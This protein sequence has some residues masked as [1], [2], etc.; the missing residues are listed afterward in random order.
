MA[1][2]RITHDAGM[3]AVSSLVAGVVS[4]KHLEAHKAKCEL[5]EVS[6]KV[7]T[8]KVTRRRDRVASVALVDGDIERGYLTL[9]HEVVVDGR[10]PRLGAVYIQM[11][12]PEQWKRTV[13]QLLKVHLAPVDFRVPLIDLRV[14]N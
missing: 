11:L 4:S 3:L 5:G 8:S 6:K 13:V 7:H 12:K 10:E 1:S 14:A 9:V 2:A